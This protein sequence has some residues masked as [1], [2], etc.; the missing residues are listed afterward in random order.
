MGMVIVEGEEAVFGV[1]LGCPI[2]TSGAF[3]V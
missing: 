1:N 2:L 3:V